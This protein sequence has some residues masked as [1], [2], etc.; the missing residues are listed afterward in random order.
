MTKKDKLLAI[1]KFKRQ[2]AE[3]ENQGEELQREVSK[4]DLVICIN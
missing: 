4:N 2:M 1:A 3:I